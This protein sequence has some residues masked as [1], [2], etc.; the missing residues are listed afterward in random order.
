MRKE[1]AHTLAMF[2]HPRC[3]C[4]VASLEVLDQIVSKANRPVVAYVVFFA[5]GMSAEAV[6]ESEL[7]QLCAKKPRLIPQLDAEGELAR[8][9]N[10][11]VSGQT[12]LYNA[13]GKV[14]FSGGLT[15]SRGQLEYSLGADAVAASLN[16]RTHTLTT[17]RTFGCSL[18]ASENRTQ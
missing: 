5:E 13:G 8:A 17:S 18:Y 4:S 16:G 14:T 10:V 6:R 2:L 7:W 3:P 11:T 12:F 9:F 1:S 15:A